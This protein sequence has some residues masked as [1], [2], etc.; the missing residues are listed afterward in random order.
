MSHKIACPA[1]SRIVQRPADATAAVFVCPHCKTEIA[2]VDGEPPANGIK[3]APSKAVSPLEPCPKCGAVVDSVWCYCGEH[4]Q[5]DDRQLVGREWRPRYVDIRNSLSLYTQ[6]KASLPY[7]GAVGVLGW[8]GIFAI[9][10]GVVRREAA[11]GALSFCAL[12]LIALTYAAYQHRNTPLERRS[13]FHRII[14]FI[15]TVLGVVTFFVL[16]VGAVLIVVG[17]FACVMSAI[18]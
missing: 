14:R 9:C 5:R 11:T 10:S 16:V 8:L 18:K 1:C 4:R 17:G 7:L 13:Q 3:A 6:W 12:V 2:N 15:L